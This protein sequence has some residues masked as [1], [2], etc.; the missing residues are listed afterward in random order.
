M[1][2]FTNK[3]FGSHSTDVST[4][5]SMKNDGE[6]DATSISAALTGTNPASFSVNNSC[7]NIYENETCEITIAY[8]GGSQSPGTYSADLDITYFDGQLTKVQTITLQGSTP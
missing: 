8:L 2:S 3:N 1:F 6:Y 7:G 4:I 5:L